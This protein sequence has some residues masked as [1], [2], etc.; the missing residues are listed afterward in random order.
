VTPDPSPLAGRT[1]GYVIGESAGDRVCSLRQRAALE[2]ERAALSAMRAAQQQEMAAGAAPAL[3][4][5]HARIAEMHRRAELRHL[6]SATIH[7]QLAARIGES[8]SDDT[9]NHEPLMH[10]IAGLLGTSSALAMLGSQARV[11]A[12]VSASDRT[13]LAAHDLELVLAEGP[14]TDAVGG[15]SPVLVAGSGLLRRWPR[16][17]PAIADL[18]VQAVSAAPLG[19]SYA[20]FGA[21]CAFDHA[22][23]PRAA[24]ADG[25]ATATKLLADVLTGILLREGESVTADDEPN[26]LSVFADSNIQVQIQQ[27]IGAISVQSGYNT[28]DAAALLAARAFADGRPV[29]DV[30]KQVLQGET[31]L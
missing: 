27:A 11:A 2:R 30:A 6:M 21:V 23:A 7:E 20:T 18:G 15:T 17:G 26:I 10:A 16:Y 13:A 24:G 31:Q 29:S 14:L 12:M 28:D 25:M 22:I 4:A 3:L 9:E 1:L 5:T 8:H 19:P